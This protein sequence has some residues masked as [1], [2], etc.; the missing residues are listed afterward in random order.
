MKRGVEHN[1]F[2]QSPKRLTNLVRLFVVVS[3]CLMPGTGA[4]AANIQVNPDDFAIYAGGKVVI[5]DDSNIH[6]GIVQGALGRGDFWIEEDVSVDG[7]VYINTYSG[8]QDKDS[9]IT[10]DVVNT[11]TGGTYRLND[12]ASVQGNVDINGYISLGKDASIGG[13]LT[14]DSI[15]LSQK[16]DV[17]GDVFYQNSFGKH[18]KADVHG[19]IIH[20][21]DPDRLTFTTRD[22][23][24]FTTGHIDLGWLEGNKTHAIAAGDYQ[25]LN[26]ANDATIELSAGTYNFDELLWTGNDTEFIIDTTLGDVILNFAKGGSIGNNVKF[27]KI[28]TN[29]FLFAA[30]GR[31]SFGNDAQID[32][33]VYVFGTGDLV[34]GHRAILSGK[35]YTEGDFY[36]GKDAELFGLG[37]NSGGISTT[38]PSPVAVGAGLF[39]LIGS[40]MQRR[41]RPGVAAAAS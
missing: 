7:N 14:A 30:G 12:G 18:N 2:N 20:G 26:I 10:G 31:T 17:Y 16:S 28:G 22:S 3:L 21:G 11:Y 19:S 25:D 5:D 27:S 13:D 39:L 36:L 1:L 33:S 32:G 34:F 6:G 24:N 15:W 35:A 4:V 41:I 9:V 29:D 23:P 38:I 40:L 8:G 37:M